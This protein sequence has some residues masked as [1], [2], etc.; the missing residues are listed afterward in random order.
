MCLRTNI[1]IDLLVF[2]VYIVLID[3]APFELADSATRR[4][5][6]EYTAASTS[7]GHQLWFVERTAKRQSHS[8]THGKQLKSC[9]WLICYLKPIISI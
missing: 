5:V 2:V 6:Y 9:S 3:A 4:F 7:V 8:H 1:R